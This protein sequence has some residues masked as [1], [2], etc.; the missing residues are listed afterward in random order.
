MQRKQLG[1]TGEDL[2]CTYLESTGVEILERNWKCRSG[3]A[4]VIAREQEDLVFIE[5][6]TRTSESAGFPE[7][8]V[9]RQKRR[10]Y[11][12]IAVEYLFTHDLPSARVRFDVMAL[13]FSGNGKAF[14]RHHRDAFGVGD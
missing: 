3:E 4:D 13:L 7:D 6:K 9:T 5:V 8:A 10:R 1:T 11:E 14:L 2:V 12:K